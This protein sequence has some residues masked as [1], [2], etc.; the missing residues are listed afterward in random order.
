[1]REGNVD[2]GDE[3]VLDNKYKVV[4]RYEY[5]GQYPGG[6]YIGVGG[7][8]GGARE[9]NQTLGTTTSTQGRRR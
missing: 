1:M 6:V 4:I 3:V 2:E 9:K 7:Q 8:I 5:Y